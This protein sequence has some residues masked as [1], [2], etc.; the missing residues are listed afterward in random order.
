LKFL[1]FSLLALLLL[2]IEAV[3]VKTFG[4]VVQRSA[5]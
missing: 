4:F 1:A 2:S 5:A 3:L